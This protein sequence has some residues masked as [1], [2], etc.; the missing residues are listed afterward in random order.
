MAGTGTIQI[1]NFPALSPSNGVATFTVKIIASGGDIINPSF[2]VSANYGS[3][4]YF[5]NGLDWVLLN[6]SM[7]Q[8]AYGAQSDVI[9]NGMSFTVEQVKLKFPVVTE[10][11]PTLVDFISGYYDSNDD[12]QTNGSLVTKATT[13][14]PS[15]TPDNSIYY[16]IGAVGVALA[17]VIG[18]M[19][20]R[21]K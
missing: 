2:A 21:R 20:L 18:Y 5:W 7:W 16:I 8:A 1:I 9:P 14:V 11:T 6:A 10:D 15:D 17:A 4:P 19:V 3:I 12:F 13:V